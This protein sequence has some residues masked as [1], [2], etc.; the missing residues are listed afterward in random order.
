[1]RNVASEVGPAKF[2]WWPDWRGECVAIVASGE[3]AKAA[4][5]DK[6]KGRIHVI[7]IKRTVDLCPWADV[8]YGCDE[9]WWTSVN[10]LPKFNGVKLTQ[11]HRA[12]QKYNIPR[13]EVKNDDKILLNESAVVG[14]GGNS[15]FQALNLAVQFGA[16]GILLV[17]F[18][19]RGEHWYGRNTWLNSTNPI[20]T[21]FDRWIKAFHGVADSLKQMGVDVVNASTTSAI[22]CFRRATIEQALE[23]WGL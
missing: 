14:S 15:G 13:I 1:V 4:G 19:M 20:S 16:T 12:S 10:G 11:A 2:P 6:L 3:S 23:G 7:A 21:N 9:P 5:V 22:K 17:G 8:V 18:D